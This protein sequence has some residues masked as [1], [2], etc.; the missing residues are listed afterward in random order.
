MTPRTEV[1]N[2]LDFHAH[3]KSTTL[4]H[5]HVQMD[6]CIS[7][8]MRHGSVRRYLLEIIAIPEVQSSCVLAYANDLVQQYRN[9]VASPSPTLT[10]T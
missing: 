7:S 8:F 9:H 2:M 5:V 10:R 4:L 6:T 3:M 1:V